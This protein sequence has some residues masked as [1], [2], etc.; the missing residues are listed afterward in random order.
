MLSSF[1][2][3]DRRE[4]AEEGCFSDM[5]NMSS[6]AYPNATTRKKRGIIDTGGSVIYD[7]YS[8]DIYHDGENRKNVLVADCEN[9]IKAFYEKNGVPSW[10]DISNTQG[11][12]TP[13]EK[14]AVMF[15]SSVVFFPDKVSYDF[16]NHSNSFHLEYHNEYPLG[17]VDGF[18]YDISFVPCD[19]NGNDSDEQ[20]A[21]RKIVKGSYR[22]NETGGKGS[23]YR[24]MPFNADIKEGDT[25]EI[26]GFDNNDINGYYNIITIP[27]DRSCLV[28]E[29]ES[30]H[31]QS[32]GC[33]YFNRNVPDMDF[34]IS[35]G[36][37]L[38]GC[39]YGFDKSGKCVNEIYASALGDGRNWY[40]FRGLSTDSWTASVGSSGA[41]TGAVCVDGYPV[42]FK[43]DTII[44]IF[45]DKPSEF[46]VTEAKAPGIE[47]GS[48]RSA[49]FVNG[50]LYY[51]SSNGIV[52]Y[53]GGIPLNTDR[54]LGREK[55]RNAVS[56]SLGSKYYVSMENE[57]GKRELFVFDTEKGIWHKEDEADISSFCKCGGELYFLCNAGSENSKIFAESCYEWCTPENDFPWYVTSTPQGFDHPDKK[58]VCG[59]QIRL[60][61]DVGTEAEVFISYDEEDVWHRVQSIRCKGGGDYIR[62]RPRRCDSYRLRISGKGRCKLVSVAKSLEKAGNVISL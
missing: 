32:E 59:L 47:N 14:N 42:F 41:F 52:R 38:W 6:D 49:S 31:V 27:K 36:N 51:K 19:I 9:R 16:L 60:L 15:G 40:K 53:D 25:I 48:A 20:S 29:S 45:G 34:V 58:Y 39:R 23:F 11:V 61:G 12:L 37:R 46:T 43:E 2:G 30:L 7:L 55:Y 28:V 44:K 3:Y 35:A 22:L 10:H 50:Y 21:L 4:S 8:L 5:K 17:D 24:N 13:G 33:I 62:L 54:A 57:K 18:Y 1:G 26:K 56:G